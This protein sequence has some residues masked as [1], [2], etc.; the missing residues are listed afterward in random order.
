MGSIGAPEIIIIAVVA[1]L[2]FGAAKLPVFAKSLGESLRIF[3]RELKP[4]DDTKNDSR[5]PGQLESR[6][7]RGP[8]LPPVFAD[9]PVRPAAP[10][11]PSAGSG[12]PPRHGDG[13]E[14]R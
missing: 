9:E 10:A 11:A 12:E 6:Q 13:A 1:I 4:P 8:E 2:L 5:Q 14:P 3:K 7:V